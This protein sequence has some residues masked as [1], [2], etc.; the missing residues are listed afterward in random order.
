MNLLDLVV[1]VFL[2]SA[3]AGGYALGFVARVASWAGLAAGVVVA[4]WLLPDV[5]DAFSSAS[6]VVLLCIAVFILLLGASIGSG[7][8]EAAGH[9]LRQA[10]PSGPARI[11]DRVGGAIAGTV[12]VMVLLWL[13]VP[14]MAEVPGV[15]A[16][17]ARTSAIAG[18]VT[19]IAPPPPGPTAT[20]RSLVNKAD[21]PQVFA[22]LRPAPDTG[23]PPAA[24]PVPA[25][26]LARA[27]QSTVNV[28]ARA[29]RR[30]QE[31][32]GFAVAPDLVM[33]N[34]HVVAGA[35]EV[36]VRRPDG[37][38]LSG[39]VVVFDDGRDLA[40]VRVPGLGQTPL[41]VANAREGSRGAVIGHPG[42]QNRPRPT[43]AVVRAQ[44]QA[45]GR[46]IYGDD[47]V[48][49]QVLFLAADL[50]PGDSGAPLVDQQG[51][52]IGVAFAIA[53]DRSATAFALPDEEINAV[54]AAPRSGSAGPCFN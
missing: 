39:R 48:R 42:G 49:R 30:L 40:L 54:L 23:A 29:C 46:D 25:A 28:E 9:R 19:D 27:T 41:P 7:A 22:E 53:P 43:P 34:A 44:R 31:G 11:L 10:I 36:Q 14:V 51:R 13:L 37:R 45:V 33:T 5:V 12:G 8:G 26:V 18:F 47:R 35:P 52:A 2:L 6:S 3:F 21:F 1:G 20:I 38:R 24:I 15:V 4:L 32:S 16:R 50:A 17:Q